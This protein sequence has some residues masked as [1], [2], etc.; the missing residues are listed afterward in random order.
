VK[1]LFKLSVVVLAAAL[2]ASVANAQDPL[3]LD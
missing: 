2:A 3:R 1:S